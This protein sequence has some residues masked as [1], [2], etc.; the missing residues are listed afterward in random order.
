MKTLNTIAA[1]IMIAVAL[2][3]A[4][5]WAVSAEEAAKLKSELIPLGGERA[6]NKDGTIP[7]WEGG[8][9]KVPDGY[10]SGQ[11][12]PDPFSAETPLFS[13]TGAN[14]AQFAAKLDEGQQYLLKKYP[15]YR[16]NVYST[17]RTA[18][19]PQ[20]VYEETYKNATR[21]KLSGYT[22]SGAYG[23]IPFP[24]PK[25]GNELLWNHSL[26]VR[27]GAMVF[28]FNTYIID[29]SGNA[30]LASGALNEASIL[31]YQKGRSPEELQKIGYYMNLQTVTAPSVR[32][33]EMLMFHDLFDNTRESWQY[34]VGQRRVRR[35]PTICCD[36]PN[37]VNS[38]VDFF[39]QVF[40]WFGPIDR[41]DWKIIG[42]REMYIPYNCNRLVMAHDQQAMGKHF[43]N[44]D[45]VRWELHRVWE[46]EGTVRAGQRDVR[47]K[48][49]LYFDEDTFIAVLGNTWDAQGTLWHTSIGFPY[50]QFELPAVDMEVFT[51]MDF[52]KGTYSY[53]PIGDQKDQIKIMDPPWPVNYYTPEALSRKGVR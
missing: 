50:I 47:P 46:V 17:H 40:V 41:Y 3:G 7:A 20:W 1:A 21:A 25:T 30:S 18:A 31:Y 45:L 13:I 32:A 22:L 51:S 26:R 49:K 19:A 24:I 44:P 16:I 6:G 2:T 39:D 43:L 12:R 15:D 9:T 11:P 34:L 37:F 10:K 42:K 38:G 35:A 36:T 28:P 48:R 14:A 5:A 29:T 52:I 23:G 8:Y 4:S 53:T 27:P 33:G